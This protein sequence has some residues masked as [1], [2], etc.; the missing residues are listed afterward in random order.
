MA[1]P[2]ADAG[3][4]YLG[5]AGSEIVFDASKSSGPI[6]SYAWDFGDGGT[7]SEKTVKH[8]YSREGSYGVT[9][10][11]TDDQGRTSVSSS[12]VYVKPL[13]IYIDAVVDPRPE[14][15]RYKLGDTIYGL[16]VSVFYSRGS[17][18]EGA[19]ISGTLSGRE[20]IPLTFREAGNGK[21]RADLNYPL[22]NGEDDFINITIEAKD[23]AGE[24][25]RLVKK[26]TIV[27]SYTGSVLMI[28]NPTSGRFAY[29]EKIDF[30]LSFYRLKDHKNMD[31]GE[32]VLYEGWSGRAFP[33]RREGKD[34]FLTYE[35]PKDARDS[36]SY[37]IYG[38]GLI[39]DTRY[40]A[41]NELGF[42][43]THDLIVDVV[44][45]KRDTYVP[46]V[47][48]IRLNVTYPD[49]SIVPDERL[50][51]VIG[52][53]PISL[54][55]SGD[56]FTVGYTVPEN[57]SDIDLWL[58]DSLGNGAG[59]KVL[60]ATTRPTAESEGTKL[61]SQITYT[62]L[63]IIG[64][65][66]VLF[67]A[68]RFVEGRRSIRKTLMKEYEET[69]QKI[70]SLK[71]VTNNVMSEYYTRK[72]TEEEARKR[73]LDCEK[74]LVIERHR[75]KDVMEKLGMKPEDGEDKDGPARPQ[76]NKEKRIKE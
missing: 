47:K 43:V 22:L 31:D 7:G 42:E 52:G 38:S 51:A 12:G 68:Y 28:Q 50:N 41:V 26:L 59:A 73:V 30:K 55:R 65:L 71:A 27:P 11:V 2:V 15:G 53:K 56:Y 32:V 75:L 33:F 69:R 72:I 61:A 20:E 39:V 10:R 19:T 18:V 25:G 29:G 36:L 44:S 48:E 54:E 9:L 6:V 40:N 34:Y 23:A 3:G 58:F 67:L 76:K 46:D 49:G 64:L 60:L 62:M 63:P 13:T 57:E 5:V 74:E 35:I 17:P 37:I 16:D 70:E 24:T 45:P 1:N 4:P 8:T 66:T 21:Y 14:T